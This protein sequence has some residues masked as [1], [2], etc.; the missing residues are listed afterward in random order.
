M[1]FEQP[2]TVSELAAW[3]GRKH[4]GPNQN[5]TGLNEIHV[6]EEGDV[7]FVDH[8]KY[9]DK[10]LNSKA[11]VVIINQ[12]VACPEGKSLIISDDPFADFVRIIRH[13]RPFVAAQAAVSPNA[14][15]GEGTVIQP[16]TFIGDHVKIGKNCIIHS[17]VSIYP[18]TVI[19]DHVVIHSSAV[20]G[21]DGFYF[22]KKN[23]AY[24]KFESGGRVVIKDDVE[25]GVACA[26]DRGVTGD[27]TIGNGCKLDNQIQIGHDTCIGNNCLIGSQCAIAGVVTIE[28]DVILW[29]RVVVNKDVVVGK[30]VIM[31]AT[32]G[33][34]KS[35]PEAGTYFGSPAQPVMTAWREMAAIRQLPEMLKKMK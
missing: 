18:H 6:V 7:T 17:N 21:A 31:L 23:G 2:Y 34:D 9:Y 13:H 32:S 27:T 22:Q 3:L 11:S 35:L 8:P 30:G 1:K 33:I 5:I 26:I 25:I 15:I 19:G 4:I 20:I 14:E 29:A 12:E 24:R 10:S 16:N 28:D